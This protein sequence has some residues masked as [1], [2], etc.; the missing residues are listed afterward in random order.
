MLHNNIPV[1]CAV[2]LDSCLNIID[3]TEEHAWPSVC[4]LAGVKDPSHPAIAVSISTIPLVYCMAPDTQEVIN[5]LNQTKK[6][7]PCVPLHIL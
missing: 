1:D 3:I 6:G 5:P 7:I 4:S 2:P